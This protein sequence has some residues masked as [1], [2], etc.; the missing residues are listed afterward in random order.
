MTTQTAD[1][2]ASSLVHEI[3]AR[4]GSALYMVALVGPPGAGKSTIAQ[5]IAQ[6]TG[7][8]VV[9]M[10]GFHYDNSV[11]AARGQLDRKGAPET[12]DAEGFLYLLRRLRSGTGA[13]IPVFDRGADLSRAGAEI[14]GPDDTLLI[15]EGNYLLLDEP[16]W[17][18][19]AELFDLTVMIDVPMTEIERRLIQRWRDLGFGDAQALARAQG[20]DLV[21][22]ARVAE[23]SKAADI[24]LGG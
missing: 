23:N 8:R 19:M 17:R 12:F 3:R 14:V 2:Q 16:I 18:E 1:E 20:N 4:A 9:P 7:A 21:N 6:R 15:V 5:G 24:R 13:A 11:L 22:A 10:D